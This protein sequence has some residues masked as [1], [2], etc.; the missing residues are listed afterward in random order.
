M[1]HIYE[2]QLLNIEEPTE[3]YEKIFTGNI[4]EQIIVFQRFENNFEK[5][6]QYKNNTESE[7]QEGISDHVILDRD[8]LLSIL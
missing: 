5:H 1:K 2:C 7:K 3:N 4:E 8:P 6:E